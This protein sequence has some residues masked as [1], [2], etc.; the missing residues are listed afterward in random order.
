MYA[1]YTG[2][3]RTRR[4]NH[5]LIKFSPFWKRYYLIKFSP[6]WGEFFMSLRS[7]ALRCCG[8]PPEGHHITK[9]TQDIL[10]LRGEKAHT[11]KRVSIIACNNVILKVQCAP[12]RPEGQQYKTKRFYIKSVLFRF[13]FRNGYA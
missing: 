10:Y 13:A 4:E 8:N 12:H 11:S 1:K 2:F 6:F 7:T 5:N 3:F 9:P